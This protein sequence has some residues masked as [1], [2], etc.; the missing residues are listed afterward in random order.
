MSDWDDFEEDTD[1]TTYAQGRLARRTYASRSFE[2]QRTNSADDGRPARFICKV[3]DPASESEVVQSDDG[4]EWIV[5]TTPA[6]RYQIKLLVAREPGNVKELWIQRVPAPGRGGAVRVLLNLRQPEVGRLLGLLKTLDS[7]AV[8]GAQTVRV[9]DDIIRDIFSDPDAL[10]RVYRSDEDRIRRLIEGDETAR[11]V[12]ALE[13]RRLAVAEFRRRLQDDSYF[14]DQAEQAHGPESVWQQF[15]EA[16][17][18]V[19]GHSL[20]SL[21]LTRWDESKLEQVIVGSSIAGSGKRSDAVLQTTGRIR[22]MVLAEIK[23]HRTDLLASR[24]YRA[25]CWAPSSELVG[26]VAQVH[27]T[28]H[29]AVDHIGERI[30]AIADDGSE[31]PGRFTYLVRPRSYLVV[32]NLEQL[33]GEGGGD[34]V[35]RIRSFELYR[36]QLAEP[37]IITFDELLARAEWSVSLAE[38]ATESGESDASPVDEP[39][40]WKGGDELSPWDG[41]EPF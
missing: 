39:S 23:T 3:F 20:G 7:I 38:E 29:R 16:N 37:E 5:R 26:A 14:D 15:F 4:S 18:W 11:D 25:G 10:Q 30:A 17:P 6:G 32:G 8:E 22:S 40:P 34:H 1:E 41:D 13:A 9:D 31:I 24:E 33:I 36:R 12:I 28:V 2:L 35:D 21:L 27:G 19:F